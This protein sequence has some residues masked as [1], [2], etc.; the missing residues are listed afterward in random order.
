MRG[1]IITELIANCTHRNHA[2][3]VKNFVAYLQ[4]QPVESKYTESS[5]VV[6]RQ[7]SANTRVEYCLPC[8]DGIVCF[9]IEESEIIEHV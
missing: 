2:D 7:C 4:C 3:P 5:L 8:V 1:G 6:A 9:E